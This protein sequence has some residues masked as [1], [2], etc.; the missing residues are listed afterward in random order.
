[1]ITN[2]TACYEGN[3]YNEIMEQETKPSEEMWSGKAPRLR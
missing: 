3:E 1:M 2:Q